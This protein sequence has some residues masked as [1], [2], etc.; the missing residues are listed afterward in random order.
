MMTAV[1]FLISALL[2]GAD[3]LTK[4]FAESLQGKEEIVV[5]KGVLSFNYVE[6]SGAA[7]G[8]L[9]N[10]SWIIIVITT[11]AI[12]AISAA[13]IVYRKVHPL[14]SLSLSVIL[15]GAI[16]NY[17]GHVFSGYVV[18]FIQVKFISFPSFNVADCCVTVGAVL[19]CV[20]IL[21]FDK[22]FFRDEKKKNKSG[23][24]ENG[25]DPESGNGTAHC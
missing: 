12:L 10:A 19:M 7:W 13:I 25:D 23:K 11:I 3:Q 6:N 15:A 16:G 21:F 18:D 1:W 17:L 8:M 22:H 20:Y 5:I 9:R 4:H 2:V 14:F 24:G